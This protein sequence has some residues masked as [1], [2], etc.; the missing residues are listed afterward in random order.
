M[1]VDETIIHLFGEAG[2]QL[3]NIKFQQV[4]ETKNYY[5]DEIVTYFW[6]FHCMIALTYRYRISVSCCA[7]LQV[8]EI[9]LA[10]LWSLNR[11]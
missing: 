3:N 11:L 4:K 2:L 5:T 6:Q 9:E 10:A 8:P 7:I 1:R